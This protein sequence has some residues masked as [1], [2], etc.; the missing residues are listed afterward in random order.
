MKNFTL[1]GLFSVLITTTSVLADEN[2]IYTTANS[3]ID[4]CWSSKLHYD[5]CADDIE[6][7]NSNY[8]EFNDGYGSWLYN[9]ETEVWCGIKAECWAEQLYSNECCE[10]SDVIQIINQDGHWGYHYDTKK[11]CGFKE[12]NPKWNDA[13][14]N[15][16]LKEEWKVF[17]KKWDK[18]KK[19]YTG[20]SVFVGEDESELNFGWYSTTSDVPVICWGVSSDLS[21]CKEYY[22]I[23]EEHYEIQ[24]VLYY[25]N[26]VTVRSIE[27]NSVYYYSR[28]MNGQWEDAIQFNTYDENNF[29]FIFV[30]D[31]QIGGSNNRV[32]VLENGMLK[33]LNEEEG[34]RNDAFNWDITVNS[35]FNFTKTPSVFLSVGDQ[36]DDEN[37]SNGIINQEEQYSAFLLPD[38]LKKIPTA[39]AVGNHDRH[40]VNYRHHFN[41]PNSFTEPSYK[42]ES[43]IAGYNYYFKYNNVLIVVL[44]SNHEYCDDFRTVIKE[45]VEKYP[46]TDWR[47]AMFHHDIYSNGY[48]HSHQS[49]VLTLRKCLTPLFTKYNFVLALNGHDHVYSISK[50]V[51]S[52]DEKGKSYWLE[53]IKV[54]EPSHDPKGTLY[55]TANCSTGSKLFYFDGKDYDYIKNYAQNF[56][57]QFGVLD[58]EKGDGMV[59]L[60]ITIR[61]V[62]THE[63]IDG[64]YI[65]EKKEC[66]AHSLGYECC[67]NPDTD[68]FITDENGNWSTQDGRRCGVIM[69]DIVDSTDPMPTNVIEEEECWATLLGFKCCKVSDTK[70]AYTDNDGNWGVENGEWCGIVGEDV[71]D[72]TTSSDPTTTVINDPMPTDVIEE[73][74]CWAIPIG[75]KCCEDPNTETIYIDADGD[76]GKENNEWCGIV[77]EGTVVDLTTTTTETTTTSETT[78]TIE[79]TTTTE[80]TTSTPE[81]TNCTVENY[82]KCGGIDYNGS[83]CCLN[84]KYYCHEYGPY[85]SQCIPYDPNDQ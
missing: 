48:E 25:S 16:K 66:W 72:S 28:F 56:T 55:V 10:D 59:R 24:N 6:K 67:R 84:K 68:E 57:T 54:N 9:K 41:T 76:W 26:K 45:A 60:S 31:P 58:F 39:T 80:I 38:L 52:Y 79:I 7:S 12:F 5:C 62:D 75:F 77:K 4:Y 35:S 53:D 33:K 40:T 2:V 47:I 14:K 34:N 43:V 50:L 51:G 49:G 36:T 44:E 65:F 64:P 46:N 32:T 21:D 63:I 8:T 11:W 71:V 81:P 82:G 70:V 73:N 17:K 29:S 37:G 15:E 61:E 22:G 1:L 13:T 78:T 42:N 18:Q 83:T 19:I 3:A 20:L 23:N 85:F 30:G 27:R 74:E 69:E